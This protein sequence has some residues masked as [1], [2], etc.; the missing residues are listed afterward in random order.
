MTSPLQTEISGLP[1]ARANGPECTDLRQQVQAE[2]VRLLYGSYAALIVHP[3]GALVAV[4]VVS[5]THPNSW[6]IAWVIAVVVVSLARVLQRASYHRS[7]TKSNQAI[8]WARRHAWGAFAAG[9]LWSIF[10]LLLVATANEGQAQPA[11]IH[12]LLGFLVV[13]MTAGALTVS[14]MYLPSFYAY[15]LPTNLSLA[16]MFAHFGDTTHLIMATLS[17]MYLLMVMAVAR[18]WSRT[19][20]E[21]IELLFTNMSLVDALRGARDRAEQANQFKSD[22]LATMSHE[23]R[24]PLNAIIGFSEAMQCELLGPLGNQRYESYVTDI[25]DSGRHLLSLVNDI[26]DLARIESGKLDL[27]DEIV[28]VPEIVDES[29]RLV[30]VVAETGG[31]QLGTDLADAPRQ[32][33]VDRRALKQ[34][35]LN[36]LSNAIKFTPSGGRVSVRV[37]RPPHGGVRIEVSDTGIGMNEE[38]LARARKPFDQA[39]APELGGP[40]GSGLGLALSEGL[41]KLLGGTLTLDSAPGRGTTAAIHLP[42]HRIIAEVEAA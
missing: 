6:L 24:T 29:V 13:G 23:F 9:G 32:L 30:R 34:V 41:V 14:A 16:W 35:L 2:R 7:N 39:K 22:F 5:F 36:L 12:M 33:T 38:Y 1:A 18:N 3:I 31:L 19:I 26:L 37:A 10:M 25:H 11:H 20:G 28:S 8:L 17:L 4:G 21:S 27:G 42:A 40:G 15:A